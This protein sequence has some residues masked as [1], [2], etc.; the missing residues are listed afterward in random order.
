MSQ[1]AT[2][3]VVK[4]LAGLRAGL[5][6]R[7]RPLLLAIAAVVFVAG[8]VI[9]WR[10]LPSDFGTFEWLP[11]IGVAIIGVPSMIAL[12]AAE[13]RAIAR[14]SSLRVGLGDS[15]RV[16]VMGTAAN[17]A[18]LP[19]AV[20][21][22]WNDLSSRGSRWTEA[23]SANVVAGAA[24]LGLSGF[25]IAIVTLGE[26]PIL[27]SV[28][29]AAAISSIIGI[30]LIQRRMRFTSAWGGLVVVEAGIIL[31]SA[32]RSFLIL[33]AFGLGGGWKA[34]LAIAGSYAF[35]NVVGIFPGGL[36]LREVL[37]G[38]TSRP[39]IGDAASGFLVSA[40]D[41]LIGLLI[42]VP[43]AATLA[44]RPSSGSTAAMAS[45]QD[46]GRLKEL[47]SSESGGGRVLILTST[48]PATPDDGRPAFVRDLAERT[49]R[50]FSVTV[51]APRMPGSTAEWGSFQVVR[52]AYF[53]RPLEGLA[54]EAIL[55]TLRAS[56]WRWIEVPFFLLSM[57]FSTIKADSRLRPDVVHAHWAIPGGLA[58]Y[59]NNLVNRTPYVVTLHGADIHAMRSRLVRPVKRMILQRASA[60]LPVSR[61]GHDAVIDLAASLEDR[62]SEPVPMGVSPVARPGEGD[63]STRHFLFVGRVADKKGLDVAIG[64]VARVEGSELTVIGSGPME[65][66]ARTL[67]SRL[68][69]AERVHFLGRQARPKVF[70]H[71]S[72]SAALLIP[73]IVAPDG[74]QE[75]TPVV[76][77]E[78][79]SLATPVIA[80]RIGGLSEHIVDGVSGLL[81]DPGDSEALAERM[82]R[83][84]TDRAFAERIGDAGHEYF[85][86]GPLSL[87]W[88]EERYCAVFENVVQL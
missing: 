13:Y 50:R 34:P 42:H 40:V 86:N 68:G 12:N 85:D 33:S 41:R 77:A 58:A 8:A 69:V 51:L 48:F 28:A 64:A 10:Q 2:E 32:M 43:V 36:G 66:A 47:A 63:R 75:G 60:I 37:S 72:T 81:F 55:P 78:A 29:A 49:S 88:T 9:S 73:S 53:P 61:E 27:T 56:P 7:H 30:V 46:Q 82:K 52:F 59:C 15:L 71:L 76:L 24:W 79:M 38:L 35:A 4:T 16:A 80:A 70:E 74:D 87:D 57:I 31:V 25:T 6:S 1:T 18:P 3:R 19:G 5:G 26:S 14:L 22:R 39:L 84:S 17:L 23:L 65:E 67:A 44:R 45:E 20:V 62:T 54:N 21:V 83:I 11:L